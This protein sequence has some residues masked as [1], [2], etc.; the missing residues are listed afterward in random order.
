MICVC[1]G[2]GAEHK[3][4]D[5]WYL[6][7]DYPICPRCREIFWNNMLESCGEELVDNMIRDMVEAI[8]FRIL[9]PL[10]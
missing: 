2:C 7:C 6:S 3:E 5:D 8:N 9:S 1:A 4:Q 10:V